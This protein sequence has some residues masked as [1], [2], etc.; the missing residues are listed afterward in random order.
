M[1]EIKFFLDLGFQTQTVTAYLFEEEYAVYIF[2]KIVWF[3]QVK[4]N[5]KGFY[6]SIQSQI[7][8]GH[9]ESQP[10]DTKVFLEK[11]ITKL[12]QISLFD[13]VTSDLYDTTLDHDFN[14]TKDIK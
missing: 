7:E 6:E 10:D 2:D 3:S 4:K 11:V 9:I 8:L 5:Q 14:L 1:K 13:Y 12:K